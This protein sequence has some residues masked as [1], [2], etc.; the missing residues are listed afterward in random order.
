VDA[1]T[2]NGRPKLRQ[3]VYAFF[4]GVEVIRR[5]PVFNQLLQEGLLR[6]ILPIRGYGIAPPCAGEPAQQI[7]FKTFSNWTLN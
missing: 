7:F 6:S 1:E 3:D 5:S 2:S 4:S